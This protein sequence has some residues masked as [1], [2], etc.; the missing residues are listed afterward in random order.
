MK[1]TVTI[2]DLTRK[3]I[4]PTLKGLDSLMTTAKARVPAEA[5]PE[6]KLSK[7]YRF[8]SNVLREH[9]AKAIEAFGDDD[10]SHKFAEAYT[11]LD[12]MLTLDIYEV[13]ET[14]AKVLRSAMYAMRNAVKELAGVANE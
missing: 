14:F 11:T 13:D 3:T 2:N 12:T 9:G 8:T 6:L 10:A 4:A 1:T 5:F 7:T